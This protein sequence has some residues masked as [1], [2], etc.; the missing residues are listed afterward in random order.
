MPISLIESKRREITGS[1][2]ISLA[3]HIGR[4]ICN[5]VKRRKT[6]GG[7]EEGRRSEE[8]SRSPVLGL[9]SG[10]QLVSVY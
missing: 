4:K 9:E 1:G 2:D 3:K 5:E 7:R 8:A 10:R 6:N